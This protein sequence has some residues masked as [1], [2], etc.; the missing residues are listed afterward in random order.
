M[1]QNETDIL[2]SN[3]TTSP[4]KGR[5]LSSKVG[6]LMFRSEGSYFKS[7]KGLKSLQLHRMQEKKVM[8]TKIKK[9]RIE[10]T[11]DLIKISRL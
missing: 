8:W 6:A 5:P 1:K 10:K 11:S 7:F 2:E 4:G 9:E 3:S